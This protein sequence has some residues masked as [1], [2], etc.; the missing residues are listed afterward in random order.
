MLAFVE[1]EAE[2]LPG[3]LQ[4]QAE[5]QQ[6]SGAASSGEESEDE[7]ELEEGVDV[8]RSL[9]LQA[10]AFTLD[11]AKMLLR[12]QVRRP[13]WR[14]HTCLPAAGAGR[15]AA[16]APPPCLTPAPRDALLVQGAGQAQAPPLQ[17]LSEGEAVRHLWSGED[18][19]ARRAVA[20]LRAFAENHGGVSMAGR[21]SRHAGPPA[22][23]DGTVV[24]DTLQQLI[25]QGTP[26]ATPSTDDFTASGASGAHG[27]GTSASDTATATTSSMALLPSSPVQ[28]QRQAADSGKLAAAQEQQAAAQAQAAAGGEADQ[29]DELQEP[30]RKKRGG[31]RRTERP[32]Q[33]ADSS[34]R[35]SAVSAAHAAR[36]GPYAP[37]V[38]RLHGLLQHMGE[39]P[40]CA[41][42]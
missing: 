2:A 10:L 24:P 33:P 40:G 23:L 1:A 29:Q 11:R 26:S 22:W 7:A 6:A 4:E 5:Q 36:W 41:R 25:G 42:C 12:H 9:R 14:T 8:Q 19:V 32:L 20:G 17:L 37:L 38:A 15:P 39:W 21:V 16:L 18:S 28:P 31:P 34:P 13:A 3:L 35:V 27:S 30:P